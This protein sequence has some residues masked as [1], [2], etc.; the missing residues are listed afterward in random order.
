MTLADDLTSALGAEHVHP[1]PEMGEP[2][3][4]RVIPGSAAEVAEVIRR[5]GTHSAAV[6][7]V[8]AGGRP[9]LTG[10]DPHGERARVFIS[11][12]RLDQVI[13]L[14]EQSLL[15][16]AQAGLTGLDL[17]RV[18]APRGLSIGDSRRS[19]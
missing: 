19:S 7:P 5:A 10:R 13:E 4:F 17:E 3:C 16:H 15:V 2:G 9:S 8:G 11:T 18:L 6:H 12:S 1:M 14:D